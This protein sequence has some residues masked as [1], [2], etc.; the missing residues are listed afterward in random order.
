MAAKVNHKTEKEGIEEKGKPSNKPHKKKQKSTAWWR[1]KEKSRAV[2]GFII[3][4]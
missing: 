3:T 2:I 1:Q 4:L